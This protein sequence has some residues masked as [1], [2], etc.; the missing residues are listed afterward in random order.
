M[1]LYVKLKIFDFFIDSTLREIQETAL[2]SIIERHGI[3]FFLLSL[4]LLFI[5]L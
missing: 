4:V 2:I 3:I 5:Q 1:V